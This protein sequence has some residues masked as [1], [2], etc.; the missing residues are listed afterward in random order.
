[1]QS[2]LVEEL[3]ASAIAT[4]PEKRQLAISSSSYPTDVKDAAARLI[5]AYESSS[6]LL[7]DNLISDIA[8]AD[9]D[10]FVD[11]R[12]SDIKLSPGDKVNEYV[13]ESMIGEGGMSIVYR[14]VQSQPI[15]RRVAIKLIRPSILAPR[16]VLRFFR[17][18][19]A[20]ALIRHP[21]VTTLYE[22]GVTE[23]G[24]PFAAME[25]VNGLPISEF[26]DKHCLTS[27][28]RMILFLQVCAGLKH[29]HRHGIV[30]R[31]VKPDNILV[32]VRDRK[33]GC[34]ID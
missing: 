17:E 1:M 13:I 22:V 21:N 9:P 18:Q 33:P 6:R 4:A 29:A 20:L 3:F 10:F 32:G 12:E 31:D 23:Q 19:Q 25:I 7:N 16:T 30:H 34:Q 28:Q 15:K 2:K 24:F 14:A 27:R 26:C 5:K 11:E 8:Q